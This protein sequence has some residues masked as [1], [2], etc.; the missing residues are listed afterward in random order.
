MFRS[1]AIQIKIVHVIR[2]TG[3]HESA[4]RRCSSLERD[5]SVV[6][7]TMA[8]HGKGTTE[9]HS[10]DATLGAVGMGSNVVDRFFRVRGA[11]GI[12][13]TVGQKGFFKS[14]GNVVGGVTLNHLSWASALGVPA[15]LAA[16]QVTIGHHSA[17]ARS[18]PPA[19]QFPA[20]G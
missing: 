11:G 16:L 9:A 17:P 12:Q 15:T 3:F 2:F 1:V 7:S 13:A 20:T 10:G 8:S 19:D 18:P 14:E 5:E 4:D 6:L